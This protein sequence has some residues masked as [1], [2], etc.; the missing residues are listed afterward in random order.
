MYIHLMNS[1]NNKGDVKRFFIK[2]VAVTFSI[3]V[4]INITYNL[5]FAEKF[6]IINK[7]L[8]L[9]N[10]ENIEQAKNKIRFEIRKG[11]AK[12]IILNEEDKKLLYE[13]YLKVKNEFEEIE[14]N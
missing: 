6:E 1:D 13:F 2:L 5:I 11:L 14:K 4:I 3:I 12:D 7:L 8:S 10:K 9:D